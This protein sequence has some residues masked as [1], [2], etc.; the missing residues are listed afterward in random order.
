[1]PDDVKD[2]P[3]LRDRKKARQRAE[4]LQAAAEL[5]REKGYERTRMEDI[6]VLADVSTPTVYNYFATKQGILVELLT[7]DR[8]EMQEPVEAVLRDPPD[9]PAEALAQLIH[10][11]MAC[12]RR[13]EDKLL[14]REMLAAIVRAHDE[15]QEELDR[16]RS[17]FKGHIERLLRHFV[18]RGKISEA[19]PL[20]LAAELI[21]A[22]NAYDFRRLAEAE[23]RT[24]ELIRDMAREQMAL[25]VA[26]WKNLSPAAL[27]SSAAHSARRKSHR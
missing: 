19:V 14:W 26:G 24:P 20:N 17:I 3:A 10:A 4:L 9:D 15:E 1:M 8:V 21:Y 13:A 11:N 25:L 12:L 7:Q 22:V 27:P 2:I 5:F 16:N 6:A 23:D 18:D